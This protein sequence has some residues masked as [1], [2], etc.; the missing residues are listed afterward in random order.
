MNLS[1]RWVF[2]IWEWNLVLTSKWKL[3]TSRPGKRT[4]VV[5]LFPKIPFYSKWE[6]ACCNLMCKW[7]PT[8]EP[9]PEMAVCPAKGHWSGEQLSTVAHSE[10]TVLTKTKQAQVSEITT[11]RGKK[12]RSKNVIQ[13]VTGGQRCVSVTIVHAHYARTLDSIPA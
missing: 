5:S 4:L 2:Q 3:L 13:K 1:N 8:P 12:A 6:C 9:T 11:A 10:P 7:L